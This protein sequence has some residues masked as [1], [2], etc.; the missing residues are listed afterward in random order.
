V[1]VAESVRE[2]ALK[3]A[4]SSSSEVVVLG[5]DGKRVPNLAMPIAREPPVARLIAVANSR[6]RSVR[7]VVRRIELLLLGAITRGSPG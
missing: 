4:S 3:K 1:D 6:S 7:D 2:P 5:V